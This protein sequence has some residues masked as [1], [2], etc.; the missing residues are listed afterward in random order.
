MGWSNGLKAARFLIVSEL[1]PFTGL[2]ASEV[3]WPLVTDEDVP[4]TTP[5]KNGDILEPGTLLSENENAQRLAPFAGKVEE[6][7]TAPFPVHFRAAPAVRVKPNLQ[8]NVPGVSPVPDAFKATSDQLWQQL[9]NWGFPS[10]V[11]GMPL[12]RLQPKTEDDVQVLVINAA[13]Q[14]L[15]LKARQQLARDR[16]DALADAAILMKRLFN[17]TRVVLAV[18]E[19]GSGFFSESFHDG[20]EILPISPQ[21]PQSFDRVIASGLVAKGVPSGSVRA[22]PVSFALA[23][24]DVLLRG[25][26][27]THLHLTLV[28]AGGATKNLR[29]PVGMTV[30]DILQRNRVTVNTFDRILFGGALTGQ[31]IFSLDTP[32][33]PGV[34]GLTI[35]AATAA[36]EYQTRPCVNCG[37]CIKVCPAH[38]QPNAMGR[39][40]EYLR[41]AEAPN[42]ESCIDCGLCSVVCPS[43]R[44][45]RQW[46]TLAKQNL[47]R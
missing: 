12:E 10:F 2:E 44:P 5:L 23:A 34:E 3:V 27:P 39:Y 47:A 1:Q 41:Y 40:C 24:T 43:L 30:R 36:D 15:H 8:P 28:D 9:K 21:Y 11:L 33:V 6:V 18:P 38:L 31:A 22:V 19:S 25:I 7:T 4:C 13:D 32:I 14:D 37:A 26:L 42:L 46:F 29:A 20:L 45:L 17:T 16:V 35:I